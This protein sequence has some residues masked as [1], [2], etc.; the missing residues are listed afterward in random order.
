MYI[1]LSIKTVGILPLEAPFSKTIHRKGA[2]NALAYRQAGRRIN[3]TKKV[4]ESE[5]GSQ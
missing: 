2:K 4:K 5:D 1:R 3:K